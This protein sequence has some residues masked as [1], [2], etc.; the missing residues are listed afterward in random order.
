MRTALLALVVSASAS[1]ALARE[2]DRYVPGQRLYG[3]IGQDERIVLAFDA[4][5]GTSFSAVLAPYRGTGVHLRLGL[6]D[7]SGA[8]LDLGDAISGA[9]SGRVRLSKFAIP[10]TGTYRLTIES[11]DGTLGGFDLATKAVVPSKIHGTAT[12]AAGGAATVEIDAPSGDRVT[13][14]TRRVR[15][16]HVDPRVVRFTD[17]DAT[18]TEYAAPKHAAAATFASTGTGRFDVEDAN[19]GVGDFAWTAIV[20]R[21]RSPQGA[22]DVAD[23]AVLG[24]ISGTVTYY[25]ASVPVAAAKSAK[26]ASTVARSRDDRR[27]VPGTMIV[28]LPAATS[29]DDVATAVA[30]TLPGMHVHVEAALSA[31]GPYRVRV[32]GLCT[33]LDDERTAS[34]TCALANVAKASGRFGSC[35]AEPFHFAELAATPS[36]PWF[37]SQYNLTQI[38]CP[39]AWDLTRGNRS[40]VVAVIDTGITPH[41]DLDPQVVPGYDFISPFG[42]TWG[43]G[44]GWDSN[45]YD[46]SLIP[47]HGLAVAGVAAARGDDRYG[48]TG[49]APNVSV[50]PIRTFAVVQLINGAI[51]DA[52]LNSPAAVTGSTAFDNAAA[53]RWAA[54]LDVPGAPPNATPA[55]VINCSWTY[56]LRGSQ[57]DWFDL[58]GAAIDE[59]HEKRPGCVIVAAAGN[60]R[61]AGSA[62]NSEVPQYPAAY[63]TVAG[64]YALNERLE[65]ASYAIH[66][67]WCRVGAPGGE[68]TGPLR[69]ILVTGAM[70]DSGASV[71]TNTG[72]FGWWAGSSF[73]SPEVAGVVALMKSVQP[74]LPSDDALRIL[75]ETAV[76]LGPP[77]F[78]DQFAYGMVD[79]RAA[80][81]AAANYTG[82]AARVAAVPPALR[83]EGAVATLQ[84]TIRAFPATPVS[85]GAIT[86][87]TEDGGSWLTSSTAQSQTPATVTVD[88]DP[89]LPLGRYR[90]S[91]T[92]Q[93]GIGPATFAVE[94]VRT[95]VV[96]PDKVIVSAI[97]ETGHRVARVTTD[98]ASG[99]EFTFDA[100]PPG[101][102]RVEAM[103]D[104]DGTLVVDRVDE[105]EATGSDLLGTGAISITP[106][107]LDVDGVSVVMDR[108]DARFSRPGANGGPIRGALAV[109][110][111]DARTGVPL[112]G[113]R[114]YLGLGG[115]APAA[116]TD[117]NGRALALGGFGGA[118]TVTVVADG[119]SPCTRTGSDAQ[120]L[121]FAL[122]PSSPTASRH[123]SVTVHGLGPLDHDVVVRAGDAV[124]RATYAGADP[125]VPLDVPDLGVRTAVFVSA[126]DVDGVPTKAAYLDVGEIGDA[127]DVT[128][129][130]CDVR[131]RLAGAA[132]PQGLD[133]QTSSLVSVADIRFAFGWVTVGESPLALGDFRDARWAVPVSLAPA[134]LTRLEIRAA[135]GAGRTSS[136]FFHS[137]TNV[138]QWPVAAPTLVAPPFLTTPTDGAATVDRPVRI[139]WTSA[140]TAALRHVVLER[141]DAPGDWDLWIG[142]TA[143]QAEIPARDELMPPGSTWTWT[144]EEIGA[145]GLSGASYDETQL[146]ASIASRTRSAASKFTTR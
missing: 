122:E 15:G 8:P 1:V 123:T 31:H 75:G 118:Q 36:D 32:E 20:R 24:T 94:V 83:F 77:G 66:G 119:Y 39:E 89:N 142:G 113:A 145:P 29:W 38:R 48:M 62:T 65:L 59:V 101:D 126:S 103:A 22:R 114:M 13:L 92:V 61:G 18:M 133:P 86:V 105:Y 78:D 5:E 136:A 12:L 132:S 109:L 80:V 129:A 16:S 33:S 21:P 115:G 138:A 46:T 73:A 52:S 70:V 64:V 88:V 98:A 40:V 72:G 107:A 121:G 28:D 104:R 43:D 134:L 82:P 144:V 71:G 74:G 7:A 26:R 91:V 23:L 27:V 50:Q 69:G 11:I 58:V 68:S 42:T 63:P 37:P 128:V 79:A 95:S 56:F 106:D 120:F 49:A 140:S 76:D 10:A 60:G 53:L 97:D 139:A 96:V 14:T 135:D 112:A 54:G 57:Q 47:S 6:A 102:Y 44:D 131:S 146:P 90:A 41:P 35:F 2:A 30:A 55:D 9:P 45:P 108:Y 4:V 67:S 87:T 130:A 141:T 19:G 116:V 3:T 111:L 85:I 34:H 93:T 110:A 137:T 99:Y 25:G 143:T 84:T 51:V 117:S 100:L 127:L 125:V 124:A 17:A 81:E